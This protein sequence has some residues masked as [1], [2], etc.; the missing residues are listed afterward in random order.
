MVCELY[1]SKDLIEPVGDL[2]GLTVDWE[3]EE[4]SVG[5]FSSAVFL[6][7]GSQDLVLQAPIPL[8]GPCVVSN[9]G[10]RP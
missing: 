9:S 3:T 8:D 2:D 1:F 6:R 5:C 7:S 4:E 10:G